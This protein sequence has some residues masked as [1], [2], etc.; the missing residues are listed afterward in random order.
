MAVTR[1][2]F[3][4]LC[5]AR[6][7]DPEPWA[8]VLTLGRQGVVLPRREINDW[9]QAAG[10]AIRLDD[11]V[12]RIDDASAG[13]ELLG[14]LGIGRVDSMDHSDYEGATVI[15]NLN[16]PVPPGLVMAY[17]VV[18]D[19]GTLEHVFDYPRALANALRMVK[20]GGWFL[21]AT[22]S[23]MWCGHG[24]YQ[25]GPEI[26]RMALQ[27]A[28][29]FELELL[30][31]G[32]DRYHKEFWVCDPARLGDS[33]RLGISSRHPATLLAAG[34]RI[35]E[36]T[37]AEIRVEQSDYTKRWNAAGAEPAAGPARSGRRSLAGI[38]AGLLP[39][40][41]R[42]RLTWEL[43]RRRNAAKLQAGLQRFDRLPR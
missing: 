36:A 5:W 29:G 21:S 23:N 11:F 26:F 6:A 43:A 1:E 18:F 4:L 33:A 14:R 31:F 22:P 17:D 32:I 15:H 30:A 2:G 3:E 35:N 19:G 34:R 27:P 42:D 25:P 39:Q 16:D 41:I 20:P 7:R 8:R 40:G 28:F 13:E 37:A 12:S 38:M 10:G 24:F 9:Q